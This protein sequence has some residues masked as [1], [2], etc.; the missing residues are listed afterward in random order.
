MSPYYGRSDVDPSEMQGM[1][2]NPF[3]N[4]L[5]SGPDWVRGVQAVYGQM[6]KAKSDKEAKKEEQEKKFKEAMIFQLKL[7]AEREATKQRALELKK[8]QQEL[9]NYV[10][11]KDKQKYELASDYFG[12]IAKQ[13]AELRKIESQK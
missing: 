11:P 12:S 7:K 1:S 4:P 13:Q 10:S 3:Y 5:Q 6:A 9:D 8:V 2:G